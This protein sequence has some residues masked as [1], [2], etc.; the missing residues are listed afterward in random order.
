MT[1]DELIRDAFAEDIPDGDLTTDSLG[2]TEK[3]G[4]AYLVAKADIKLSGQDIFT[5][6]MRHLDSTVQLRWFFKDGDT[7]LRQQKVASLHGDLLKIIK[8]ERVALNFLGHLSGIAT[9]THLYATAA[10]PVKILDTRKT[11]PGYRALEK[12]AV[13]DGGGLNHRMN[14]SDAVLIKENHI[15]L[16]GGITAAVQAIRKK[17]STAIEVEVTSLKRAKR[18]FGRAAPA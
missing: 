5:K 8:A 17:T 2:L 11:L 10:A 12:R 18:W 16:A 15:R 3:I 6:C 7:V 4:R 9:L 14:L 1:L 13:L